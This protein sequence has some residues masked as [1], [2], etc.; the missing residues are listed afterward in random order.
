MISGAYLSEF[1]DAYVFEKNCNDALDHLNMATDV[2]SPFT[3]L[4][5]VESV[6]NYRCVRRTLSEAINTVIERWGGHIVRNNWRIEIRQTI[7]QDRGV[8]LAYGK[9]IVSIKAD[10]NWDDVATKVLPVGKDGL[11]LPEIWLEVPEELYEIPFTKVLHIDQNEIKEEDF[12]SEDDKVD[13]EAYREAL[14]N[15]LR[16]KGLEYLSENKIPKVN[17]ALDAYLGDVSDVGDTIYVKHPKCKIDL[18]T[19]VIALN[20][21]VI[22]QRITKVEFGNFRKGLKNL[23]ETVND[24]IVE[25]VEMSAG[26]TTAKLEKELTDAT[27]SIKDRLGSS[28]VI[29]DGDKIL[30]VDKLPKEEATNVIMINDGGIGFS[31]DGINGVFKSAWT[32]DGILNMQNINV[33]NLV[34][35]LIKGG[36]LKLGSNLNESGI[37][38]L[39]DTSNTLICLVDR[40]G[41]TVYC[42]DGRMIKLN[43]DVGF[44]GY[45]ADGSKMFWVDQTEFHM[46]KSVIETE[47]TIA[48]RLRFIPITTDTNTGMGIVALV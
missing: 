35:D 22:S 30:I 40:D 21:D 24:S 18:I 12:I 11:L 5:D 23:L 37:I 47:I 41:I 38:E 4:S 43:A 16:S 25:K 6:N 31:Q 45:D 9:N 15:D 8:T 7:G 27:N 1:Q 14:I 32:I 39:Y 34:A 48:N 42:K 17:Y 28:Y 3:T 44:V 36:T 46:K 33:I 26:D 13:E 10:E 20:F 2:L 19:N 29:V